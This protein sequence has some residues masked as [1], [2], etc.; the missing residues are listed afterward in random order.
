[1]PST[2]AVL[3]S[4]ICFVV[5]AVSGSANGPRLV[6]AK[7]QPGGAVHRAYERALAMSDSDRATARQAAMTRGDNPRSPHVN[8]IKTTTY[9][10]N[11][12]G[13][14]NPELFFR[15]ELFDELLMVLCPENVH[16]DAAR[17]DWGT[18]L[19]NLGVDDMSFWT[20]LATSAGSYRSAH[21]VRRGL[22]LPDHATT[23]VRIKNQRGD[24][25]VQVRVDL[26]QCRSRAAAFVAAQRAIGKA[27]LSK[28]LYGVVAPVSKL[29]YSTSD[30]HHIDESLYIEEGCK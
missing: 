1:M 15:Y 27:T 11:I 24:G 8:A 9:T 14:R 21:C 19:R 23:R 17:R 26:Q 6:A 18:D 5:T 10:D 12:D 30:E 3:L 25:E 4:L 7:T 16:R 20:E 2:R 28:V 22:T 13:R 29:S